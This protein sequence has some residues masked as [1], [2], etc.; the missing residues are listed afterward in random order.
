VTYIGR[1]GWSQRYDLFRVP[2]QATIPA[3]RVAALFGGERAVDDFAAVKA[4][5][6]NCFEELS[7]SKPQQI[8]YQFLESKEHHNLQDS[9]GC[10]SGRGGDGGSNFLPR[11]V[12]SKS[13]PLFYS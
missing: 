7:K 6:F 9:L 8:Q 11:P 13:Y 2:A 10:G 1:A 3:R 4:L 5:G 12:L